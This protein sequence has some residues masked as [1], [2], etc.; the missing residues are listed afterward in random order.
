MLKP[1]FSILQYWELNYSIFSNNFVGEDTDLIVFCNPHQVGVKK[2]D[3][4]KLVYITGR[5]LTEVTK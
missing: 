3:N 2:I 1:A 5:A 4:F